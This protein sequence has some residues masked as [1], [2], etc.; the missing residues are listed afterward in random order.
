MSHGCTRIYTDGNNRSLYEL[1]SI[2][3]LTK[4]GRD[5]LK[6]KTQTTK[7]LDFIIWVFD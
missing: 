6:E 1:P 3:S 5:G 4:E 2:P 7:S